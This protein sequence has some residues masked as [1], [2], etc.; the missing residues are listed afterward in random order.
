[1]KKI[2]FI[3]SFTSFLFPSISA[4]KTTHKISGIIEKKLDD[5]I[6]K[7]KDIPVEIENGHGEDIEVLFSARISMYVWKD[8]VSKNGNNEKKAFLLVASMLS[9]QAKLSLENVLSFEPLKKQFFTINDQGFICA[10]RMMG[11]NGYG[12][13]VETS[14]LVT[15]KPN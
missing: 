11:R 5:N 4:Q 7:F 13:L 2:L 12:N 9:L 6:Y 14:A 3:L 1:M 10:F 8:F 15:Y